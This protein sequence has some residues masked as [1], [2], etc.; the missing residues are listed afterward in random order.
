MIAPD[1]VLSINYD[2]GCGSA[3]RGPAA[4]PGT[5]KFAPGDRFLP[6]LRRRVEQYFAS[7]GRRPR[8]CPAMYLKT[9]LVF[10]WLVA[11]YVGLVC[12]AASAWTALPL[13]VSLGLAMAAVGFNVQHDGAH[14]AFSNR[15]WINK[16]MALSLDLL[17]G[18]S[19]VWDKKHN[20]VHH[21]YTNVTGHDDDINI[22]FFGRLSPHQPRLRFHRLQ[23]FYLWVLYGFLPIKWQLYDDFRDVLLGRVGG[24]RMARPKGWD[25][26]MFIA[27][28]AAFLGLA[29]G[30]PLLWHAAWPVL[31]AYLAASWT[32]GVVLST[33]FQLAHC[34]ESASFPLP[35][36]ADGRMSAAWAV[37]QVETTVDFARANRLLSWF[38][39]GLNF[40]IEHHL[41]PRVCHLHYSALAPI[42]ESTCRQFGV[43]YTARDSFRTSLAAHFRWLRSMGMA[44]TDLTVRTD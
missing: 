12:W 1:S 21:S 30:V 34:E 31:L 26:L 35:R 25:L 40:Q 20:A 17:G 27:G 43:R 33:V 22:T 3:E 7:T 8:D 39:G 29:F 15:R 13:A 19:Y 28:K 9:V 38:I 23:H 32:Q 36:F 41:F 44:G 24:H 6:E 10:G 37:H 18:S 11:S 16:L 5:L 4:A 2:D 14:Q 42:V